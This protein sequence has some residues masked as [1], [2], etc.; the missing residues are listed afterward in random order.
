MNDRIDVRRAD[1]ADL[2]VLVATLV[3]SHLDYEWEVWAVRGDDRADRMA[4]AYRSDLL[5]IAFPHGVVHATAD[6]ASV[7]VWVP[8]SFDGGER[9]DLAAVLFG[10]RAALVGEV[11]ELVAASPCPSADWYLAT[12][13]TR[14]EQQR[15]GLGAAV[16]RPMLTRLDEHAETARL[17]TSSARNVRF[18]ERHGFVVVSEVVL[19]HGAPATWV[20]HRPPVGAW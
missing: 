2:D 13:G 8:A 3:E 4:M 1:A 16:L 9:P 17:E 10:D 14:P 19:P 18:Y 12:M 11:D 5:A 7:A 20:M 15:Q 6:R